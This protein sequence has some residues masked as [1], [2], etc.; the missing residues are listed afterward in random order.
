MKLRTDWYSQHL[1]QTLA[2]VRWG[3][4][5]TPVLLFPTAGG[6]AEECERFLMIQ[7][8]SPLLE[9][10]R[11]KIYSCDSIAGRAWT[12]REG[13][14]AH[15]ARVQTRWDRFIADELAGAIRKDCNSPEMEIVTAGA[16]IGAFAA[17]S[18]L[19]RHPHIF[20]TAIGLSGTYDL[21]RWLDGEWS[22]D[23]YFASPLHY[24]PGLDGG[25]QLE[26]LRERFVLLATGEGQW[27][28]PEESWRMAGV[29]GDKGVPNRVDAWGPD[30]DHNWPT[31]REML[32]KY[33][34]ELT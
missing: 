10:G 14:G 2:I 18:T 13:T 20:K 19:C 12:S 31:W 16:S 8:L 11:I 25:P 22:D 15:R 30:Y 29:L 3:H 26:K 5:G 34:A 9:A 17:V 1:Q 4:S 21:S 24:L 7:V 28:A 33:L 23:F 27:E 32:P 6:D